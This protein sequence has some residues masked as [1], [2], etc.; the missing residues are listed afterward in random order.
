MNN[1]WTG[2]QY[3]LFRA[4]FGLYLFVHFCQLAPWSA[5][6]FSS[7]G[8]LADGAASPLFGLLPSVLLISDSAAVATAMP[9]VAAACSVSFALGYKDRIA[10]LVIW[11][12]AACLFTRNPLIS[13]PSL[14]YVGWMLLAHATLPRAPF[15][16]LEARGRADPAGDWRLPGGVFLA[17]WLVLMLGYSYSGYTKL[18]SPSWVDG[19]ALGRV[20]ENP[21]ARDNL[22][23]RGLLELPAGLLALMTWGALGLELLAAPLALSKRLR[24]WLWLALVSMHLGLI[25]CIDFA[26]LSLAM[27]LMHLFCFDPAWIPPRDAA[28]P[29]LLTFYDG[30]CG[31]C[32]RTL[33]VLIAED[34]AEAF[35]FAPLASPVLTEAVPS[36]AERAALP[37]SLLVWRR[38]QPLLA[39]S[40]AV[41]TLLSRLGGLWRLL[42]AIGLRVP[43]GLRDR[44]YDQVA[45]VRK[46]VFKRPTAQCPILPP[47]LRALFLSRLDDLP[48]EDSSEDSSPAASTSY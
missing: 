38:G 6:L 8:V 21:L 16:S 42:A 13:N 36:E 4:A 23:T 11:Y 27:L 28:A 15:G 22:V 46:R 24:P 2:G 31:L 30:D 35:R 29:P 26:E 43:R 10:A 7:T 45:A 14:P 20:L 39:R 12:L 17:A 47:R 18:V 34:R 5:E 19:S 44:A 33:R 32:H 9:I 3:S 25:L 48:A 40:D 1:A 37:D 41:L